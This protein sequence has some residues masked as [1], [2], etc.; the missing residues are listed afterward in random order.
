MQS[1]EIL[2]IWQIMNHVLL[3]EFIFDSE[4]PHTGWARKKFSVQKFSHTEMVD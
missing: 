4:Q 1:F 2:D 3:F